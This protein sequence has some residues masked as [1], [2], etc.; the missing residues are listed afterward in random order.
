MF[1]ILLAKKT[2]E[3]ARKSDEWIRQGN[4]IVVQK[5]ILITR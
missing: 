1:H 3:I 2:N 5:P 4:N